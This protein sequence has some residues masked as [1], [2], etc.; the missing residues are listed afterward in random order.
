MIT[1]EFPEGADDFKKGIILLDEAVSYF[2]DSDNEYAQALELLI[3]GIVRKAE[4]G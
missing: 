2:M 3:A 1:I 4:G